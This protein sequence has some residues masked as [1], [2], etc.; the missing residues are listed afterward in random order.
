M[1][2]IADR[3]SDKIDDHIGEVR[4]EALDI[5]FGEIISLH[6]NKELVIHPEYQRLFRWSQEQRSRLIESI[7]LELPIPQLFVIENENGV[8]ELI[9]G[10]Q[11]VSSVIQFIDSKGIDLDP[12]Q[13]MGCDLIQEL[14]GLTFEDLP[15]RLRLRIKR[16]SVRMVMIKRQS[17]SFLRYEMFKRLNTGGE[18]LAPQEIR[19]CSARMVGDVGTRFYEFLQTCA[20]LPAFRACI[21]PISEAELEK[22]GDEEL[23]L[24]YLAVKNAL[25]MF[26]GSVRDWLD[27][28]MEGILLER[29]SFDYET[30][31][32]S[33]GRLFSYLEF[34]LGSG[35]FVKYR[36]DIP[37]GSLAP[38]YYEA[39]TMG[40]WRA[41]DS[42]DDAKAEDVKKA[43]IGAVQS[44]EFREVTGPGANSR[45]KL[46]R[47]IQLIADAVR[48]VV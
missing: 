21:E 43:V 13:L 12:L 20:S 10:L 2:A 17:R 24:R 23:V 5:S 19:N 42:L 15:L 38:A 1:T 8:L 48:V 26:R 7:L 44:N 30:E 36:A 25:D 29:L 45:S 37:I 11:R 46:Y 27:T 35:A 39:V 41:L 33:F 9:D 4:T 40:V 6:E 14:N 16:S 28:Y 22:K 18:N 34:A 31:E 3:I 47:R 32:R